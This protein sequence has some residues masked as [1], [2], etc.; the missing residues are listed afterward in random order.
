MV[1]YCDS[2]EA[3]MIAPAISA[4]HLCDD[5]RGE[6]GTHDD[7]QDLQCMTLAPRRRT[8]LVRHDNSLAKSDSND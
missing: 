5:L 2:T 6:H 8:I 1:M 4:P 3:S 7:A